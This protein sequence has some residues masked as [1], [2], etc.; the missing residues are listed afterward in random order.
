MT[1]LEL[2]MIDL[3][4]FC[5]FAQNKCASSVSRAEIPN[6]PPKNPQFTVTIQGQ[7]IKAVE[8]FLADRYKV[9]KKYI[10]SV[11]QT[12]NKKKK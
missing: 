8:D 3:A 10:T 1:G 12:N 7:Q 2:F 9:P 4:E 6:C 11:D 5:S